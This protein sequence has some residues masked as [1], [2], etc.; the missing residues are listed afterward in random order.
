MVSLATLARNAFMKAWKRLGRPVAAVVPP[1]DEW[2]LPAGF[3][4]DPALDA[5]RNAFGATLTNWGDYY[6]AEY[7]Y[8]VPNV[9]SADMRLLAAA[10]IVPSGA[11]E[12]FVLPQDAPLVRRAHAL[13]IDGR[14]YDVDE[15]AGPEG[16]QGTWARVR[17]RRRS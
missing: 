17:L 9:E 2:T 6:A 1:V 7:L 12:I 11:T 16:G 4:Y 14:W 13:E 10:G 15:V 3:A 5:V 8:I